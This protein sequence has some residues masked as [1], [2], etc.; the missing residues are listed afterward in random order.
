MIKIPRHIFFSPHTHISVQASHKLLLQWTGG[1]WMSF[2]I[3]FLRV[4]IS[5][6]VDEDKL[7]L[8]LSVYPTHR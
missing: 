4:P 7:L 3:V 8:P 1:Y 6:T 2:D 5:S